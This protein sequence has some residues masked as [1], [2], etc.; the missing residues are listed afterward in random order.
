PKVKAMDA[1]LRKV[2]LGQLLTHR[3]GLRANAAGGL[4]VLF[5]VGST[6]QQ[7]QS[8]LESIAEGKLEYEPGKE[9]HYSNLGYVLAGHL[10]EEAAGATWEE[11]MHA[12]LFGP[13]GMKSAGFGAMGTRGKVEQPWQHTSRGTPVGPGTLSDNPLVI[14]PAGRVHCSVP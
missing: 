1:G 6:R 12:R 8:L 11:L 13:L 3:A 4:S 9:L 2:T 10:A 5:R 7:R 14:G